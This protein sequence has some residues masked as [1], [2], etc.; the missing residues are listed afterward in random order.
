MCY[1][2]LLCVITVIKCYWLKKKTLFLGI[3]GWFIGGFYL[4]VP[5]VCLQFA[6]SLPT[7]CLQFAYSCLHS[8]YSL[9]KDGFVQGKHYF[10][11]FSDVCWL[12]SA[13]SLPTIC[14]QSA[15]SLSTVYLQSA[16]SLPTVCLQSAYSLPTVAYTVPTCVFLQ[17]NHRFFRFYDS[18]KKFRRASRAI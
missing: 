3:A 2:V 7:V 12:N 14:L 18:Q 8:A 16:Y 13:S 6:Y 1:C 4:E 5:T 9:H 11:G 10:F 17:G 15:Y